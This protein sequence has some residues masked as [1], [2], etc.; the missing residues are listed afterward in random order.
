MRGEVTKAAGLNIR[1]EG[2]DI[3]TG[4]SWHE[5]R[6]AVRENVASNGEKVYHGEYRTKCKE[7]ERTGRLAKAEE[8]KTGKQVVSER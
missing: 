6:K 1:C 2:R 3:L 4:K 7:L 8:A 5:G